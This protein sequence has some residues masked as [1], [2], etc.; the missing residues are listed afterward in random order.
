MKPEKGAKNVNKYYKYIW[1]MY[2]LLRSLKLATT[3]KEVGEAMIHSTTKGYPKNVI[4]I[5]DI[6]ALAKM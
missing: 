4:E 3:I 2:P 6:V 5:T 1:W